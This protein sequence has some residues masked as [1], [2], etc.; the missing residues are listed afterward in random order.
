MVSGKKSSLISAKDTK[1]KDRNAL[2]LWLIDFIDWQRYS[3]MRLS[4]TL[5]LTPRSINTNSWYV[6]IG[7]KTESIPRGSPLFLLTFQV[8]FFFNGASNFFPE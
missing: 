2:W 6:T 8:K 5:N 7:S 3:G 1:K 4:E